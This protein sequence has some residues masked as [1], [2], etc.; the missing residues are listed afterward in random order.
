MLR[1]G[2]R[3]STK[4][5]HYRHYHPYGF[6]LFWILISLSILKTCCFLDIPGYYFIGVNNHSTLA[7]WSVAYILSCQPIES[8][9]HRRDLKRKYAFYTKRYLSIPV[10]SCVK[11]A[12]AMNGCRILPVHLEH[13]TICKAQFCTRHLLGRGGHV[14]GVSFY[15]LVIL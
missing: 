6:E 13:W 9:S 1:E 8:F 10:L 5:L 15:R 3:T 14:V 4:T 11:C 7:C 12:L 2:F